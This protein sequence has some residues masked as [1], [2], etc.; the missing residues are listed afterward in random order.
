MA[1][2]PYDPAQMDLAANDAEAAL[3]DVPHEALESVA[4]WWKQHYMKAGHK[5]LGRILLQYAPKEATN[6]DNSR[7]A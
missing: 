5:R 1:Y 3:T 4:T 2:T 6:A 7:Q